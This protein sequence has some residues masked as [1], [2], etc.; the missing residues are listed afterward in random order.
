VKVTMTKW[1]MLFCRISSVRT[2]YCDSFGMIRD[3]SYVH[4]HEEAESLPK[5]LQYTAALNFL[6]PRS[7]RG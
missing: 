3:G 6:M 2:T 5:S 1:S 4:R 7:H